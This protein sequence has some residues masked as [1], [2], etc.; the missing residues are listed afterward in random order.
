MSTSSS[1]KKFSQQELRKYMQQQRSREKQL[2]PVKKIDS[3]LAKYNELGQL[4]C[5]LCK[6]I[7][8]SEAVWNVHINAK[9][10]KD[11]VEIA[12]KLK[13]RTNNF[14]TP[15]KRPLTPPHEVPTKRPKSIL[16][17]STNSSKVEETRKSEQQSEVQT[18]SGLPADFFD[19]SAKNKSINVEKYPRTKL[20]TEDE[21]MDQTPQE[22][23]ET[24]PEGFF[25][26]P[27]LDA[28]ARNIEYKD[29]VQE[30]WERFQKEI[31]DAEGESA[32]IIA[33]DQEEATVERQID[34]IDEQ[35][36]NFSKVITWEKK[37]VEVAALVDEAKNNEVTVDEE[38]IEEFDEYFDWRTKNPYR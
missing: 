9:L 33:E 23:S 21:P 25:D 37:R 29:P 30:E 38:E 15:L 18:K 26:D 2:I 17:N 28:K 32:A 14:T 34:E 5:V 16:K 3:P 36:K 22:S 13:E 6:T 24:L 19:S 12:K 10:H 20:E 7:V 8:R 11:N 31:K 1:K 4:T 35:I 27:K